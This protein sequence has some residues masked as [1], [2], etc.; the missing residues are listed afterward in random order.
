MHP[1]TT[2]YLVQEHIEQA[3]AATDP[4]FS[5][6]SAEARILHRWRS[7][8][9]DRVVPGSR[10]IA[11]GK[12]TKLGTRSHQ[13]ITE[14]KQAEEALRE[15]EYLLSESERIGR[16]GT[17]SVDPA[18]DAVTWTSETYR[19]FGVLPGDVRAFG[20]RHD[21]PAASWIIID[22]LCGS[23][24]EVMSGGLKDGADVLEFRVVLPDGSIRT[25]SG[26]GEMIFADDNRPIRLA[27]TVQD[28]T[29]Q[30][31]AQAAL[32]ESEERYRILLEHGFDGIFVHEDFRIVEL[33]DRLAEMTGYTRE[34]LMGLQP[35]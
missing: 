7:A 12:T 28:V 23:R 21:R 5:A 2:A 33:N 34:E 6:P 3:A 15:K 1:L 25:L 22:L 19:L 4:P 29:E 14:R 18:T 17:W 8:L 26:R 30:K 11:Q 24:C 10:R 9:G 27:G 31:Q 13:D 16:I 32:V 20:R 35:H